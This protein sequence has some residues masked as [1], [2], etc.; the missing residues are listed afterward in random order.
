[1]K[2]C[3]GHFK[4]GLVGANPNFPLPEWDRF[5]PQ[6]NVTLNLLRS[7]RTN[8]KLSACACICGNFNSNATPMAPP[9][10]KVLIHTH[11]CK[12]GSWELNSELAWNAGPSPTQYRCVQCYIPRTSSTVHS[13]SVEFFPHNTSFPVV[14]MKCYLK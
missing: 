12:R 1:M 14:T 11:Q 5:I 4:S 10:T 9:G 13:D 6:A 7:S 2:I 3:K 8:P